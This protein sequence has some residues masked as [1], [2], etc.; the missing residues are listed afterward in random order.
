MPAE[1]LQAEGILPNDSGLS[2]QLQLYSFEDFLAD[3]LRQ[4]LTRNRFDGISQFYGIVRDVIHGQSDRSIS[5]PF[6]VSSNST[7]GTSGQQVKAVVFCEIP[8][9]WTPEILIDSSELEHLCLQRIEIFSG[10]I[11]SIDQVVVISF[12]NALSFV[13]PYIVGITDRFDYRN[14]KS[15]RIGIK[16]IFK[17]Q[18][19]DFVDLSGGNALSTSKWENDP[20]VSPFIK[21]NGKEETNSVK[22]PSSNN[23]AASSTTIKKDELCNDDD[24]H[25]VTQFQEITSKSEILLSLGELYAWMKKE[26][27]DNKIEGGTKNAE[28]IILRLQ[29]FRNSTGY[30]ILFV[31]REFVVKKNKEKKEDEEHADGRSLDV[32]IAIQFDDKFYLVPAKVIFAICVNLFQNDSNLILGLFDSQEYVHFQYVPGGS[33]FSVFFESNKTDFEKNL[34][35]TP[36]LKMVLTELIRQIY[37]D[38]PFIAGF[39]S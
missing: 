11:P 34:E 21:F 4:Q 7:S 16:D 8:G 37:P 30:K 33:P 28:Q 9:T 12:K 38:N 18:C 29:K 25:I 22:Q 36:N 32:S 13:D 24:K 1:L 39:L 35:Q 20:P 14:N 6:F 3:N 19:G 10:D 31:P 27:A 26:V 23:Q 17:K 2:V 15:D 5:S